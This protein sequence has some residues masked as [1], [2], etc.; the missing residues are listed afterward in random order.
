MINIDKFSN[1]TV[2]SRED[3][4]AIESP[5]E[6][7]LGHDKERFQTLAI[8]L[9]TPDDCEDLI[10][11]YLFTEGIIVNQYDVVEINLFDNE[12]GVIAEIILIKSI[13]YEKYLNK[14]QGMVHASCGLCG[15]T[16]IDDLLTFNYIPLEKRRHK[17]NPKII[18]SLPEKLRQ[19]QKAFVQT[20]GIH[21]SALFDNKGQL[22]CVRED[23][24]RHNALDKL[25]GYCLQNN[26]LPLS[27]K[28]V[29]L[30]GR[31]SFELVH[32]S[33]IAGVTT[34]TAIGAP[35]SLSIEVAALN[36]LNLLGF[37]KKNGLNQYV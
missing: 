35:S 8:T 25:I 37:V 24:G 22:I 11:G 19:S 14:R 27:D 16:E 36:D 1:E 13:T 32:K 12:L 15:K 17:T 33:L 10:Y 4:I 20:G 29:L 26:L 9:C 5:L 34:L 7:R 21:A 3:L 6:L 31:V 28:I 23:I 2:V 30:S 18:C